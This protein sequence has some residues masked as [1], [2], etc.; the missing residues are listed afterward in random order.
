MDWES[1]IGRRHFSLIKFTCPIQGRSDIIHLTLDCGKTF[2][3]DE[4]LDTHCAR[5]HN[6]DT[7]ALNGIGK[8]K[9][10]ERNI[11]WKK[12]L[13]GDVTPIIE[14]MPAEMARKDRAVFKGP[15]RSFAIGQNRKR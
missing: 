11:E 5:I 3:T 10:I 4:E 12:L 15:S 2:S 13:R 8:D 9:G 7:S 1:H 14:R 6:L